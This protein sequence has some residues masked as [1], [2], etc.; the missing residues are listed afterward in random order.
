MGVVIVGGGV[1]VVPVLMDLIQ[2]SDQRR[3]YYKSM[4]AMIKSG[5]QSRGKHP[6]QVTCHRAHTHTPLTHS[7]TRS[8]LEGLTVFKQSEVHEFGNWTNPNLGKHH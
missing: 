7:H 4:A 6:G 5:Q 3:G 1:G 8:Y 2:T